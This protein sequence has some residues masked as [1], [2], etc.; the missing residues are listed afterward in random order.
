M[1][2]IAPEPARTIA[3]AAPD[4]AASRRAQLARLYPAPESFSHLAG[5][6]WPDDAPVAGEPEAQ[7][8]LGHAVLG[9]IF[10][11]FCQRLHLATL[12]FDGREARLL[13]VARGGLRLRYLYERWCARTGT[14]PALPVGDLMI[15]RVAAAKACLVARFDA[16]APVLVQEFRNGSLG[17]MLRCLLRER[18]DPAPPILAHCPASVDAFRA[19]YRGDDALGETLRAYF[20]EQAALFETYIEDALDGARTPVLVDTG[21]TGSTQ[22]LLMDRFPDLDWHGLYFGRW[23]Y[24]RGPGRHFGHMFGVSLDSLE[25]GANRAGQAL[26]HYHHLIED[27]LEIEV[28]SVEG[29]R[30]GAGAGG[31]RA[32]PDVPPFDP[33]VLAPHAD[34]PLF[35][36]IVAHLDDPATPL[37]FLSVERSAYA[38]YRRLRRMILWP[39]AAE[40][41]AMVVRPRSADF[42]RTLT[43]PVLVRLPDRSLVRKLKS[44]ATALWRPGQFA[45]TFPRLHWPIN[46]LHYLLLRT[47]IVGRPAERALARLE[48]LLRRVIRLLGR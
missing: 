8:A 29:Y 11:Q 45:V 2:V 36:G 46:G 20:A 48:R 3:D 34:G 28:P 27:P 37:D 10:A 4:A 23:D 13:F 21:W 43:V 32:E 44:V 40:L 41:P 35:E 7:R 1:T 31:S 33:A 15:S 24:G 47:P 5:D 30:H 39:R 17:Y 16:V 12:A 14:R 26:F 38:A 42:G 25:P 22:A 18:L 19:A 9:P 6:D